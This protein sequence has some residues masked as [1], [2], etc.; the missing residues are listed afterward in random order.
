M[1]CAAT[2]P[3][4]TAAQPNSNWVFPGYHPGQHISSENA[5]NGC[6]APALPAW[7]LCTS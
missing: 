1:K 5:S 4:N 6:S 3:S 7:E 2:A